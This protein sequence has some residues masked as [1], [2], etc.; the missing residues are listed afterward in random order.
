MDV[1]VVP[2][3]IPAVATA[4]AGVVV[5]VV[6]AVVVAAVVVAAL[7]IHLEIY[8]RYLFFLQTEYENLSKSLVKNKYVKKPRECIKPTTTGMTSEQEFSEE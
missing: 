4:V 1:A 2:A 8:L 7:K 3:V 6:A 5:T